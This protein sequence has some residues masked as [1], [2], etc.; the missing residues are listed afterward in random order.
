MNKFS[1]SIRTKLVLTLFAIS[2]VIMFGVTYFNFITN[3][4]QEKNSFMQNSLIQANLLAD[5]TVSALIFNDEEGANENLEKLRSDDNIKRV[6]IFDNDDTIF[7]QYNPYNIEKKATI[8]LNRV[9]FIE[10]EQ[11]FLNYGTLVISVPLKHN[12]YIYGTL[13][14]EKSTKIITRLLKKIFN[15]IIF[16]TFILL[17]VIYFVSIFLSDYL[18]KPIL[19]LAR[20]AEEIASSQNYATRV[21]YN[22][23]NE[24]GTLYKS[25]NTLVNDTENLTNNLEQKVAKR[26]S[27]LEQSLEDLKQTQ[28]KLI[29]SEKMS[30]LGNLVSGI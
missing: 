20:T 22:S 26:T 28:Q 25:F 3:V 4:K 30:A 15:E 12:D 7:S 19:S 23:N 10:E 6:I 27:E 13:Y 9:L 8:D 17:L 21:S 24:I 29:E 1:L 16:F 11:K 14:V 5:F 2:S 18:L